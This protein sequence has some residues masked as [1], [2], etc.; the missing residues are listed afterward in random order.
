[1]LLLFGLLYAG[2]LGPILIPTLK[3]GLGGV[4]SVTGLPWTLFLP[5]L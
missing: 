4:E 3:W 5:N 2:V 1:M